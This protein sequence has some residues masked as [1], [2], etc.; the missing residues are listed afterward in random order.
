[1]NEIMV[2]TVKVLTHP[3]SASSLS[4]GEGRTIM[5]FHVGNIFCVSFQNNF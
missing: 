2:Y 4:E 3:P 5:L 1:M